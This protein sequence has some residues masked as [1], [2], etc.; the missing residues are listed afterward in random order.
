MGKTGRSGPPA[1]LPGEKPARWQQRLSLGFAAQTVTLHGSDVYRLNCRGYH[2]ESGLGAP[3]EINS[4]IDPV[5]STSVAIIMGRMKK[6]GMDIS[7]ASGTVLAKQTNDALLQRF[8][9]GGQDMPPFPQLSE[10]EI[11]S[12][13]PY[14]KLLAGVP[15]G[16]EGASSGNRIALQCRRAHRE[17]HVSHLPQRGGAEPQHPATPGRGDTTA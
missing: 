11:R 6:V 3:P 8:H 4:I 7:R 1:P 2:E 15:G 13:V 10:A 14:L 9:K 12:L 5:R 16:R 17:I